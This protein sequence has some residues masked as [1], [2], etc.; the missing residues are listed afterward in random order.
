MSTTSNST[1]A[2]DATL[3]DS[4]SSMKLGNPTPTSAPASQGKWTSLLSGAKV[5]SSSGSFQSP[6]AAALPSLTQKP[7]ET[8][9]AQIAQLR[10]DHAQKDN[11]IISL[12]ERVAILEEENCVLNLSVKER[13]AYWERIADAQI[14]I[15]DQL[16]ADCV[17]MYPSMTIKWGDETEELKEL[18]EV[19][20][21]EDE[22]FDRMVKA[23]DERWEADRYE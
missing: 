23:E 15:I 19:K 4:M 6:P 3:S 10:L 1:A 18:R 17:R 16:R 2:T 21:A 7:Y 11:L 22:E 9:L 13:V 8:L 5:S 12:K 14:E 20:R